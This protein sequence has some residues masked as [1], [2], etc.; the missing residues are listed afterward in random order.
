MILN[1]TDLINLWV[2]KYYPCLIDK[3]KKGMHFEIQKLA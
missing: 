2:K 3:A 1:H